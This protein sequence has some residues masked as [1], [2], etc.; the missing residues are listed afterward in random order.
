MAWRQITDAA[1]LQ[2]RLLLVVFALGTSIAV[3]ELV[4]TGGHGESEQ[5]RL[6]DRRNGSRPGARHEGGA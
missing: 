2:R 4:A 6:Q 3:R 1:T 5:T